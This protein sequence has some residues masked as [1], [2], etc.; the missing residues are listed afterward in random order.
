METPAPQP[1]PAAAEKPAPKPA[2][3]AKGKPNPPK[4][5]SNVQMKFVVH[6]FAPVYLAS[7]EGNQDTC[8]IC[9][10]S[11]YSPCSSCEANDRK[12]PCPIATGKCGHKYHQH[13][14]ESWIKKQEHKTCPLCGAEF[15]KKTD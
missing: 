1:Q 6:K 15:E 3:P 2:A 9:K 11:F 5:K 13:C 12:E 4:G 10:S 7:W 14:I 8:A